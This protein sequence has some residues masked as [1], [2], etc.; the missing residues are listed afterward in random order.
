MAVT[1]F[2]LVFT[3]SIHMQQLG[4]GLGI[5]ILIDVFI[6]RLFIVPPAIAVSFREEK[7]KSK[8]KK[9]LDRRGNKDAE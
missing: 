7:K 9:R 1:Y 8:M 6:S 4:L 5:G 3:S 2:S